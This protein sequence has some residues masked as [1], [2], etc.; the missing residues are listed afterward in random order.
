MCEAR[1]GVA[2][3]YKCSAHANNLLH[4]SLEKAKKGSILP[5]LR[6]RVG[7]SS[8]RKAPKSSHWLVSAI[9]PGPFP[10][11]SS[12]P[13]AAL[14]QFIPENSIP[15]YCAHVWNE[16]GAQTFR[17]AICKVLWYKFKND[18]MPIRVIGYLKL[19]DRP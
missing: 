16:H 13:Q 5:H 12:F 7:K 3:A 15:V 14:M 18:P 1:C 11:D 6:R 8:K 10:R 17:C 9:P 19:E 2:E 4:T